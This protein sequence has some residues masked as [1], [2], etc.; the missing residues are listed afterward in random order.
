MTRPHSKAA[1]SGAPSPNTRFWSPMRIIGICFAAASLMMTGCAEW[2]IRDES[3]RLMTNGDY[4]QA[5]HSLE[6]GLRSY[7]DSV[8]L[9]GGLIQTRAEALTS[10]LT[11]VATLR[12]SGK[13]EDARRELLRAQ[14]LDPQNPRLAA[15]L[16]ELDTEKR[17]LA[18]LSEAE[19]WVAKKQPARALSVIEQALKDNPRQP[20]LLTLQRKLELDQ[21][22]IEVR[23][24]QGALGEL[25]PISLDF[26]EASLRSVLDVVSRNSGI[27][28]ILDKDIRQDVRITVLLRQAR[29]E[30]A[31]DLIVGTNQLAKKVID[32]KTIV[33]YP[34]TLEKQREYQEQVVRVFY[35]A[36]AEAKGAAAFLKS[37]LKIREPFVDERSNMLSLRESPE[38]IQLAERLIALYDAGEPEVL[39]DVEVME[40]GSTR[41]TNLGIKYPDTFSLTPLPA[42]GAS[43][44]TLA[45]I[46]DMGRDRVALGVS[47]LI[48]NFKREIGDFTTL[49]NPKIRARNKEKAKILIG[50]KIP[51][52]STTSGQGG[53]VAESVSYIDVGIKLDVEPTVYA[54]N[55][56]AIRI[57]LEVSALGTSQKT[58]TGNTVYQIGTRNASTLLRLRDGE[59]QLLAGLISRDDRTA[60]S[61]VPGVGDLPM[62]GRLFSS[63]QDNG[64][65]TELVLAITPH[66]LRNIRRPDAN[67]TEMWVG[68]EAM[69]KLRPVG[70]LKATNADEAT[71][72]KPEASKASSSAADLAEP[73]KLESPVPLLQWASATSTARPGETIDVRVVVKTDQPLRGLPLD[74]SFNKD[75]LQLQ[76]VIEGDFFQQEG[77]VT[78]FSKTGD[79]LD[80]RIKVG[81]L[82]NQASGAT[83]EGTVLTL[84]FKAL[85]P[86]DADLRIQR[87]QP[88]GLGAPVHELKLPEPM[89]LVIR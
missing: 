34:N 33:V 11:N 61:R 18:A 76:N 71:P 78:S 31:L 86:G 23:T 68:T 7:P 26:R 6:A 81:V 39:L 9:R 30:D 75:V 25:R 19:A 65:R 69:P 13:T 67:E 53:F 22:Q 66:I 4:E 2:H 42:S 46:R 87:A 59:T 73:G 44:L 45:N 77:A 52:V 40:V 54:D 55:D 63:Q 15:L 80:G 1:A 28:F 14:A 8:V 3:K 56:V 35:L 83:G 27:N 82:R 85:A 29:V 20:S 74:L 62:V 12:A 57:A 51:I 32:A 24:T 5:V 47:G 79:G 48:F 41:L 37:M 50:D 21:R 64:S 60:A 89:A 84:R 58:S 49:A 17:Q 70:G 36:S 38:N 10:I 43:G 88:L 72:G 16:A